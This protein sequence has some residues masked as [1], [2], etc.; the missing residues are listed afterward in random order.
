MTPYELLYSATVPFLPA[1]YGRV[2]RDVRRLI[3]ESGVSR[4]RLLDVGG[5]KSP[6]T[7]GLPANITVL[8]IP[9]ESEVQEN[10]YLG[11]TEDILRQLHRRRSNISAV[12]LQDMIH[13]TLPS[14]SYDGVIGVEVIEHIMEDDAFVAQI[15]R[16]LRPGGWLYL[17]TPNGDYIPNVPPR[18]NPDHIK[19]FHRQELHD[20]LAR[21]FATVDVTWGIK[22]GHNRTRGLRTISPRRPLVSLQAMAGNVLNRVESRRWGAQPRRT[23]HLIATA[24]SH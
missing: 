5:R 18:Y 4:P 8:D 3:A 14:G 11:V 1:L 15:A 6:Y 17:T 19:H 21:H 9:R 23:A 24:F 7:A 16:V 22:T 2:R 20:L 13:C 10:L 12:V